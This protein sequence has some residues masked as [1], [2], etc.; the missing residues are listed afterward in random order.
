MKN[1]STKWKYWFIFLHLHNHGC[2]SLKSHVHVISY[3]DSKNV[4]VT[5]LLLIFKVWKSLNAKWPAYTSLISWSWYTTRQMFRSTFWSVFCRMVAGLPSCMSDMLLPVLNNINC[6]VGSSV[7][8]HLH[9][10]HNRI[11]SH[12]RHLEHIFFNVLLS[13]WWCLWLHNLPTAV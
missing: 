3:K 8:I 10:S 9:V 6:C 11:H 1:K 2:V 13:R 4:N 12:H 5:C 7:A